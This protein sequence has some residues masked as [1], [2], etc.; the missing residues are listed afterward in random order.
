MEFARLVCPLGLQKSA[1]LGGHSSQSSPQRI[2]STRKPAD[3][4]G[5]QTETITLQRATMM[6][7]GGS[8]Q[9]EG[10]LFSS[11]AG[12]PWG[13]PRPPFGL[14]G[15]GL[16]HPIQPVHVSCSNLDR[17]QP[18]PIGTNKWYTQLALPPKGTDPIYPLPYALAF[19]DGQS[20]LSRQRTSSHVLVGLGV[21]H[22][23]STQRVFG[24]PVAEEPYAP[25]RYYYNPLGIS[26]CLGAKE[27]SPSNVSLTITDWSELAVQV[28]ISSFTPSMRSAIHFPISRGS[29]F[30]TALYES[31]TPMISS[32]HA[33]V[34][35]E[36]LNAGN[37]HQL[38]GFRKHRIRYSDGST[39]LI[40]S[41]PDQPQ[42]PPLEFQKISS[43]DIAHKSLWFGI[44][45]V[46]T[47]SEYYA[48]PVGDNSHRLNEEVVYDQGVGVWVKTA[49]IS[50]GPINSGLYSFNWHTAGP[51]STV[52]EP[53]VFALPHHIE[54]MSSEAIVK[55]EI[56]LNSRVTGEMCLCKARAWT[57]N[58][59]LEPLTNYGI[60][61]CTAGNRTSPFELS[62][63]GLLGQVLVKELETG[64]ENEADLDSYYFSGKKL[65]KQALQCLSASCLLKR[66]D[67]AVRCVEKTKKSFLRFFYNHQ[68]AAPLVYETTWK[69]II[70]SSMFRSWNKG[71]DF[72]NG[73][74]NDHH[75][76]FGYFIYTAAV[77]VYHDPKLLHLIKHYVNDLIRD[78]NNPDETDS[79]FPLFRNFDWFLGH[80]LA[81]GLESALDGK[82]QESCS[83][84]ANFLYSLKVWGEVSHN[85]SLKAL[86]DL[87]LSILKRSINN[88]YYMQDSNTNS[89]VQFTRNRVA[90]IL[91][92]NKVDYTTFFSNE[93]DAIHMIQAIPIT[94]ITPFFR[95]P[96][97]IWQE[98]NHT[99]PPNSHNNHICQI[100]TK[101]TNGYQT[102]LLTQYGIVDP[103]YVWDIF[104]K[105]IKSKRE[106]PID[107]G[108]S[109]S[110]ILGFLIS[111]FDSKAFASSE[112]CTLQ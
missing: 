56:R 3:W 89:P 83:E 90:G 33:I 72:G 42:G 86:A 67:L 63:L 7:S 94:P 35:L 57:F 18:N 93:K 95:S 96:K 31:L 55:P 69:G 64:F 85:S 6:A 13:K 21:S 34:S 52:H 73:I 32:G 15:D 70:S 4:S 84:D 105:H 30:I 78:I 110:W 1:S 24:P 43:T 108:A 62:K 97:F 102:L 109:L 49:T 54:A 87:Q 51:R 68:K 41:H 17:A 99:G 45:Q 58:E 14:F 38:F 75:F 112:D 36:C 91:F 16:A 28:A 23:T 103:H 20:T 60:A 48:R 19:L 76:H 98:W 8:A 44:I 101:L 40:Y 88:Y 5:S 39:W 92:E 12:D 74:Y 47:M 53:L 65:A 71:D 107:D 9:F 79:Y 100:A 50:S 77:L 29:A 104:S 106:V 66:P 27:L 26:V 22:S 37:E 61:P 46:V 82:N 80:S 111:Q 59:N 81:T 10:E 2:V 25:A 11:V